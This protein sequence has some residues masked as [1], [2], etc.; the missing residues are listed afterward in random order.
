[1]FLN[2]L[3]HATPNFSCNANA[4]DVQSAGSKTEA[5]SEAVSVKTVYTTS[6]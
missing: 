5:V 4:M 3:T 2:V 6:G 1:M